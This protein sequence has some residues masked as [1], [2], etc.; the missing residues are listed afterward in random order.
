M[1]FCHP[2]QGC[3]GGICPPSLRLWIEQIKLSLYRAKIRFNYEI[4]LQIADFYFKSHN[5][6]ESNSTANIIKIRDFASYRTKN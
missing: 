3:A 4:S 6:F 2:P 5:K 1:K